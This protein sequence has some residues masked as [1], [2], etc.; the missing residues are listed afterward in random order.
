[1]KHKIYCLFSFRLHEFGRLIKHFSRRFDTQKEK[2]IFR[3]AMEIAMQS[4]FDFHHR[5]PHFPS[6]SVEFE[7]EF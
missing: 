1:M 3:I 6:P 4:L 7:D 2:I 5:I